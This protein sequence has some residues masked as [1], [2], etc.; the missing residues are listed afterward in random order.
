[1]E[2]KNIIYIVEYYSSDFSNRFSHTIF[3]TLNEDTAKNYC[4]KYNKL[5][6]K[7][8]E[9]YSKKLEENIEF[10]G[11]LRLTGI[12]EIKEACYYELE[13]R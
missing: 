11:K 12:L 10:Y 7:I 8:K 2:N 4:E 5:L 3:S 6:K 1:M 9:F 13:I